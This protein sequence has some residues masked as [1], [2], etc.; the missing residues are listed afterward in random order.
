MSRFRAIRLVTA[1]CLT[2]AGPALG[3]CAEREE[4]VTE[5]AGALVPFDSARVRVVTGT[6]TLRL[7]VELATSPEQHQVGLMERSRLPD[8]SGMLFVYPTSQPDSDGFW[9]FRTKIPLDIAFIDSVGVIRTIHR[10]EPCRATLSAGCPTYP[11]GA[12]FLAALEV[13]AGYFARHS[14]RV[15]DRVVLADTVQRLTGAARR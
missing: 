4:P 1:L 8:S 7:V 13:N 11:A 15:G 6:D 5:D 12:R 2:A 14:V 9:M 3:A 10:M